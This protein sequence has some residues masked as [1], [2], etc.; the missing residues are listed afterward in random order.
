MALT[1]RCTGCRKK[2]SLDD[3]FA[4][5]VCRCPYCKEIVLVGQGQDGATAARPEA[6]RPEAPAGQPSAGA[7]PAAA[8]QE[9]VVVGEVI[10]QI[11]EVPM[12]NPVRLQG[13]VTLVMIGLLLVMV[14]G[15]VWLAR[16]AAK[17]RKRRRSLFAVERNQENE[18]ANLENRA[19]PKR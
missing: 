12:A 15:I 11:H 8:S 14:A 4:G 19:R 13:I 17:K 6:P 2:I 18:Q 1:I 10:P 9:A 5:G 3:G 7:A 16:R